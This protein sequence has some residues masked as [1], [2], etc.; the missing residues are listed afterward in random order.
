MLQNLAWMKRSS[1]WLVKAFENFLWNSLAN[2]DFFL[3]IFI[4]FYNCEEKRQN[5]PQGGCSCPVSRCVAAADG[6]NR[7]GI[8]N[9][10]PV[11][12]IVI[13]VMIM[14]IVI[15]IIIVIIMMVGTG[16]EL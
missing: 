16:E 11:V 15:I 12:I 14:I 9:N 4:F 2:L 6:G 8:V 10:P 3:V 5:R 7:G 13:I 1:N